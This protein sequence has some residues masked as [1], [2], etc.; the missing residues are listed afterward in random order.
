MQNNSRPLPE[1]FLWILPVLPPISVVRP[2]SRALRSRSSWGGFLMKHLLLLAVVACLLSNGCQRLLV[3]CRDCDQ[4]CHN[5]RS[6]MAPRPMICRTTCRSDGK[7]LSDRCNLGQGGNCEGYCDEYDQDC[8]D[9]CSGV[10]DP[11]CEKMAS[12]RECLNPHAGGYPER[13]TFTPGP[14]IGQVAYPYYTVRG[15]RD[16]LQDN[17]PSI[18]PY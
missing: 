5:T 16:F 11:L 17:P 8:D 3:G 6:Q 15:P 18:G 12:A 13:G 14:P 9:G 2:V 1:H 4:A 10:C 7:A